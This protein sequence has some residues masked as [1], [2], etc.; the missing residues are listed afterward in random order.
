MGAFN[1]GGL[2]QGPMFGTASYPSTGA[3]LPSW[4]YQGTELANKI[5][6]VIKGTPVPG[7]IPG[8]VQP[9]S[10]TASF[11]PLLLLAAIIG[12]VVFV[13][14]TSTKRS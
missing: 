2:A 13:V 12:A 7:S 9:Q 4:V 11:G 14:Y 1:A 10:Q 8:S 5:I 6:S 3:T